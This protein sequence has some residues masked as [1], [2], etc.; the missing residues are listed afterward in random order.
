[1]RMCLESSLY[2]LQFEDSLQRSMSN[3]VRCNLCCCMCAVL[4]LRPGQQSALENRVWAPTMNDAGKIALTY[5]ACSL[6][7]CKALQALYDCTGHQSVAG[8][9]VQA[10]Q[11]QLL[12]RDCNLFFYSR[13]LATI[14]IAVFIC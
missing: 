8:E 9:F 14:P 10:Q 5:K 11:Q 12:L 3:V 6:E 2:L 1:M 7:Y 13:A 4:D